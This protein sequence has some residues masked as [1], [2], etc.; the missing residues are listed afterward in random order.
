ML[1]NTRPSQILQFCFLFFSN[2]DPLQWLLVGSVEK[3]SELESGQGRKEYT[4]GLAKSALG[5]DEEYL[6]RH[7]L[8]A[9]PDT[10]AGTLATLSSFLSSPATSLSAGNPSNLGQPE[11][12]ASYQ[13]HWSLL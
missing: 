8:F 10:E 5:L 9:Q 4:D 6:P 3:D 1:I 2:S 11:L 12:H 13:Q 7:L